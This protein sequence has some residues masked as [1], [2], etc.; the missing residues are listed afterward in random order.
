MSPF[1]LTTA[2][3]EGCGKGTRAAAEAR[4]HARTHDPESRTHRR[5]WPPTAKKASVNSEAEQRCNRHHRQGTP[6]SVLG[7]GMA[8]A[9]PWASVVQLVREIHS[10]GLSTGLSGDREIT[11]TLCWGS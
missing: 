5:P 11:Q 10:G 3:P 8:W 9:W 1:P 6:L 2:L 4:E 7:G